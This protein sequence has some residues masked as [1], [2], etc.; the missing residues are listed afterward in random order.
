MS[1]KAAAPQLGA[2]APRPTP[3]QLHAEKAGVRYWESPL[4]PRPLPK[5]E[6]NGC[7]VFSEYPDF[8]PNLTP[9][10]VLRAGSFGGGYFRSIN[11]GVAKRSFGDTVHEEFP[12]VWFRDMDIAR[13][14][15]SS[16]YNAAVNK[17]GVKSGNGLDHWEKAGWMREQDPYGW[18]QWYCRFFL[19]RRT[20]DDERQLGR[21]MSAIG[22]KGRWRC[23]LAGQCV[24]SDKNWDDPSASPVTRQ[25]L[26]H[27]GYCFTKEDWKML[28]PGIRDG[29]SVVYLGVV[30]DSESK[31]AAAESKGTRKRPAAVS[32]GA[33]KKRRRNVS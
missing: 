8:R 1:S 14:V 17:Y 6:P 33:S 5:R 26:L 10:E 18:F 20:V 24:K 4:P 9:E 3:A 23:Y 21:W 27:W 12:Q 31:T 29:K 22:P 30:R 2:M 28:A 19:G 32:Q 16:R 13:C 25:T 7:L 15:T 11:S